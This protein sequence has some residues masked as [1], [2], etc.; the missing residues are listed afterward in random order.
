[1]KNSRKPRI[2]L[3]IGDPCGIGPE[4][5]AKLVSSQEITDLADIVIIADSRVFQSG[6]KVAGISAD[7]ETGQD[8]TIEDLEN[9]HLVVLDKPQFEQQLITT[10]QV[11]KTSGQY[12]LA[13]LATALDLCNRGITDAMCFAPLNKEAMHLAGLKH[14]D[15]SGFFID[16]LNFKGETGILNTLGSLWTSRA[17]SHIAHREVGALITQKSVLDAI[18]LLD[19]TLRDCGIDQPRIAVAGLNPHAGDGG[20]FGDE[21]IKEIGPAVQKAQGEGIRA[22]GPFSPDTIFLAGRD[23]KYDAVVTMY[24]DQG[25]IAMKLMGF[26]HGVTVHAGL[27]FPVTTSGHGSALDIAGKGIANVNALK[28]AFILA[29]TMS[30]HRKTSVK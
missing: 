1:M 17:T 22:S 13:T 28:E 15:E 27:P 6:Q 26:D 5:I 24:H 4:L 7:C 18:R 9:H 23:G 10:G 20:M 25:Q 19:T 12:Q 3:V 16:N 29:C 11:S 21:E 14:E 30:V 2:S 8:I